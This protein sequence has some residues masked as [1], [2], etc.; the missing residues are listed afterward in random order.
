MSKQKQPF[1]TNHQQSKPLS[2][3]M[4][5]IQVSLMSLLAVRRTV[6][7]LLGGEWR[8]EADELVSLMDAA[9]VGVAALQHQGSSCFS[10]YCATLLEKQNRVPTDR[11]LRGLLRRRQGWAGFSSVMGSE[12][13]CS[14]KGLRRTT[15]KFQVLRFL[16]PDNAGGKA[17]SFSSRRKE[18]P[19]ASY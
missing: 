3:L 19:L 2:V 12:L 6:L 10:G 7:P 11:T 15:G 8:N 1:L 16:G 4:A 5:S 17:V 9:Q 18:L 14:R 13:S